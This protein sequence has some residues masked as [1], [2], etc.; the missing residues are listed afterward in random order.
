M[1]VKLPSGLRSWDTELHV[2]HSAADEA[3][4]AWSQHGKH[5]TGRYGWLAL[6]W[7]CA[8]A[9][10]AYSRDALLAT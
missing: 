8:N 2:V 6:A 10:E 3:W 4:G 5:L 7:K 9:G 1:L